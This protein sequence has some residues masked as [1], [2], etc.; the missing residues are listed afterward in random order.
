MKK[1]DE[2]REQNKTFS[3]FKWP[4]LIILVMKNLVVIVPYEIKN[5]IE[6]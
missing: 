4:K 2:D 1:H 3:K 5:T 6:T